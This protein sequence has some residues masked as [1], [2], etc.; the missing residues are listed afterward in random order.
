MRVTA[1]NLRRFLWA[2][3]LMLLPVAW[4]AAKYDPYGI[5]GDAV[6][7]MDLADLIHAGQWHAV[8]N[9]YWHPLYPAFLA[10][11]QAI[12][13]TSRWNELAAYYAVNVVIF[14]MEAATMLLLIHG[15]VRLR[16]RLAPGQD[17]L[18]SADALCIL[19]L[20]LLLIATMRD[21]T[22]GKIRTDSLLQAL[23]FAGIGF[24]LEALAAEGPAAYAL[25]GFMGFSFGLAYLTKSFAFLLTLLAV[26]VLTAFA[27]WICKQTFTRTL[28]QA[29]LALAGF[30]VVAGPYIAALSHQQGRFDFGDSGN[31][32]YVWY[33]SGT[34]KFH[35]QPRM[36]SS[37][38]SAAVDLKHPEKELM[39]SPG[40]YSYR[41]MENGTYPPWFSPT[42]W[43][44]HI[45]PRFNLRLLARRD[46]RNVVLIARYLLNHP[47][48]LLLLG[49]VLAMCGTLR[50]PIRFAW[51]TLVLGVL[52]WAIYALVNVE[53]RYVTAAFLLI[54]LSVFAC[55][56]PSPRPHA[57]TA[58]LAMLLLFAVLPLGEAVRDA[59]EARRQQT[60]AGQVPAWRSREIFGAAEALRTLGLKQGDTIACIGMQACVHDHYWARLAGVRITSEIY[61]PASTHLVDQLDAIPDRDAVY[62]VLQKDGAQVLVGSFDPGEMNAQ[63]PGAA[64]WQRLGN[65]SYY[66]LRLHQRLENAP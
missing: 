53:E 7:Y 61:E 16:R 2:Y 35:L 38:G 19:G 6:S 29:T 66:V 36:V 64:G 9:G 39:Q 41:A 18:F 13:H 21:M 42:Y 34:E 57:H 11:G 46:A 14:L 10:A 43:N 23:M 60:I 56:K 47:E 24:M 31:L 22:L 26:A 55:L 48:S 51:P 5:D 17:A 50:G 37:F 28:T 3:L 30:A 49:L 44:D 25:S 33:V 45:A 32:N 15:L 1:T 54:V 59:A 27:R 62:R 58:A 52:I 8:V 4:V 12:F 20:S 65:T 40:V 63:H